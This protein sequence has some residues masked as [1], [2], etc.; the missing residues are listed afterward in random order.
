ME[1]FCRKVWDSSG[2]VSIR[3]MMTDDNY[4]N[5]EENQYYDDDNNDNCVSPCIIR[6][7][8]VKY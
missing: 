5:E 2:K 8:K 1:F 7:Y 4:K 3:M 6:K